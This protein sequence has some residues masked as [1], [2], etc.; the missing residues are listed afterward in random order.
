MKISNLYK[1]LPAISIHVFAC[2]VADIAPASYGR[3]SNST[4]PDDEAKYDAYCSAK[5]LI[6]QA[7]LANQIAGKL[8]MIDGRPC[9]HKTMLSQVAA[10]DWFARQSIESGYYSVVQSGYSARLKAALNAARAIDAGDIKPVSIKGIENWIEARAADLGLL[11]DDGL[12]SEKTL[13]SIAYVVFSG[14]RGKG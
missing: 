10:R 3:I 14:R 2:L 6:M 8:I 11:D 5:E 13:S 4:L 12:V 9:E 7:V 1:N